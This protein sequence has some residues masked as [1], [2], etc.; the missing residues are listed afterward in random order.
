[1][2]DC[3]VDVDVDFNVG[4]GVASASASASP[5]ALHQTNFKNFSAIVDRVRPDSGLS[6]SLAVITAEV[7]SN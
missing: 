5:L 7:I 4:V 3:V 6:N 1:M 2:V